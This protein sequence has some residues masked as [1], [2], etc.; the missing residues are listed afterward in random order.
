M[1]DKATGNYINE[2]NVD[3][4]PDE[5][6]FSTMQ[7]IIN[8]VEALVEQITHDYFYPKTFL[9]L[10]NGNGRDRIFLPIRQKIL[11]I[12]Y[13]AVNT[14]ALP[15][16]DITGEGKISGTAG[17]YKVT[18]TISTTA[19]Y[20]KNYYLGIEDNSE[21]VNKFW[22]CLILGNTVTGDDGNS[23]FTLEKPLKVTLEAADIVS[24]ITNW[25]WDEDCIYRNPVGITHEP[26]TLMEPAEFF[27]DNYF[28]KGVR[29]IEVKGTIGHYIYPQPIK[30]ACI[31]LARDENDPTLYEHYEFNKESMGRVY[32]YDRGDEEYISGIIEA[33]RY[34]RRYINRR[35]VIAV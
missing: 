4:W 23:V 30:D 34:L 33:D 31:I 1:A 17:E 26:G 10:L 15:T 6:S 28:P 25:A 13:L 7:A 35:V 27:I 16:T 19:D 21:A 22:G 14:I 11:S 24:L 5:S 8:G 9:D 12:N 20:Y 2:D 32:S 18:L 3:N 29:N